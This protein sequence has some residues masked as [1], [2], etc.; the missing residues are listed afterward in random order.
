M[1]L[2][3]L[4]WRSVRQSLSSELLS[5]IYRSKYAKLERSVRVIRVLIAYRI[6]SRAALVR[7]LYI[8]IARLFTENVTD[9]DVSGLILMNLQLTIKWFCGWSLKRRSHSR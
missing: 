2:T 9:N 8:T 5:G 1:P 3:V 7:L 4:H 6:S